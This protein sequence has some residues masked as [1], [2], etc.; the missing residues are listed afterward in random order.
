M[1][2]IRLSQLDKDALDKVYSGK[3]EFENQIENIV[4]DTDNIEDGSITFEKLD[5]EIQ[6]ILNNVGTITVS[7]N[8][9]RTFSKLKRSFNVV[10][11]TVITIEND[12]ETY[13]V[14]PSTEER[15][16][17]VMDWGDG[18]DEE[19]FYLNEPISHTYEKAG[20]YTISYNHI[21][22]D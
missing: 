8:V 4:I 14:Y 1:A 2:G 3:Q 17:A 10:S 20:E 9:L 16:K 18:S 15:N 5:P 22:E 12:N 19:L 21:D 13:T 6:E 7:G 11:S